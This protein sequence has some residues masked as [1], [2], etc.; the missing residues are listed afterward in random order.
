MTIRSVFQ[1]TVTFADVDN[2]YTYFSPSIQY[3]HGR[4]LAYGMTAIFFTLS[5]VVGLPLLLLLEPFLNGK[6]NFIKIKPLLD[7]FQGCYKDKYRWFAAYYMICRLIII[8]I[9]IADLSEVFIS[10]YLLITASTIMAL[11]HL[12]VRPYADNI[13]NIS[14]GAILQLLILV[15][16]LPLF[17]YFDIFDSNLVIAIAFVLVILPLIQFV[18]M[19]LYI[20]K[21]NIKEIAKKSIKQFFTSSQ[22]VSQQSTQAVHNG[23]VDLIIDGNM[24]KNATICEM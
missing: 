20:F 2:V 15:T 12:L 19:K 3:F 21:H 13:L 11:I 7:Q 23:C 18:V 9:I 22:N 16:A 14:D 17:E 8:S 6:I 24:R 5:I 4:H 10:R 1:N